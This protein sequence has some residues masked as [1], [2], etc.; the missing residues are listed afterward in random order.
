M[1]EAALKAACQARI[2]LGLTIK[3]EDSSADASEGEGEDSEDVVAASSRQPAADNLN[4]RGATEITAAV[5]LEPQD[6]EHVDANRVKREATDDDQL[7][8]PQSSGRAT[9]WEL[10]MASVPS[11]EIKASVRRLSNVSLFT[12]LFQ[13]KPYEVLAANRQGQERP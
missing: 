7:L 1:Q 9:Y 10:Y 4:S 11:E 13:G 12:L 8:R 3:D 2:M 6:E 5:E